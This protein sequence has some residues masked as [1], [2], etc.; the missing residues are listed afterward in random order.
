M[1]PPGRGS[2]EKPSVTNT[3]PF[4]PVTPSTAMVAELPPLVIVLPAANVPPVDT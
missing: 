1:L 3:N 2:A 4:C